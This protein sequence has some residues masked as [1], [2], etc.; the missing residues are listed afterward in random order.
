[1]EQVIFFFLR[2]LKSKRER[3][4]SIVFLVWR[5]IGKKRDLCFLDIWTVVSTFKGCLVSQTTITVLPKWIT[6]CLRKLEHASNQWFLLLLLE[7]RVLRNKVNV[8]VFGCISFASKFWLCTIFFFLGN[9]RLWTFLNFK[10]SCERKKVNVKNTK[11][12]KT[13]IRFLRKQNLGPRKLWKKGFVFEQNNSR[14]SNNMLDRLGN[15]FD[16]SNYS[17]FISKQ[18][19][20][21]VLH[22]L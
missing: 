13:L 9:S 5:R 4:T 6:Y 18:S 1:M 7:H 17:I 16:A 22:A 10:N 3:D 8:C 21:S 12:K 20:S 2:R 14:H 11:K 15:S 19:Q